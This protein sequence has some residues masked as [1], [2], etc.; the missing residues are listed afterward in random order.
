MS[1]SVFFQERNFVH[2]NF[3]HIPLNYPR[4]SSTQRTIISTYHCRAS[5]DL[6]ITRSRNWQ[7]QFPARDDKRKQD[8]G[9]NALGRQPRSRGQ[10]VATNKSLCWK[11]ERRADDRT[12][13]TRQ[14]SRENLRQ[15]YIRQTG[16]KPVVRRRNDR[17][18]WRT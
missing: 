12:H 6:K 15:P 18:C 13:C 1:K 16:G 7:A 11:R 10:C 9:N 5:P 8:S 4:N 17:C 3:V 2:Q 14:E